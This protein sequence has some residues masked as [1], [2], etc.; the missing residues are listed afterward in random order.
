MR[1]AEM[2]IHALVTIT[3]DGDDAEMALVLP[4]TRSCGATVRLLGKRGGPRG[5]MLCQGSVPGLRTTAMFRCREVAD[6]LVTKGLVRVAVCEPPVVVVE[7]ARGR[8]MVE[9]VIVGPTVPSEPKRAAVDAA[10]LPG[11]AT[12]LLEGGRPACGMSVPKNRLTVDVGHVDCRSCRRTVAYRR[13]KER[14]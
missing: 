1:P 8:V 12:H 10:G 11:L 3:R 6:F 14:A 5:E 9:A 2:F 7:D 13:A 4:P